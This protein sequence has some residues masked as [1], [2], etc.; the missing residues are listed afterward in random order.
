MD[1]DEAARALDLVRVKEGKAAMLAL[2][3]P[4]WGPMLERLM[5]IPNVGWITGLEIMFRLGA[6]M[7]EGDG[8][9]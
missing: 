6:R 9:S 7:R 4:A 1:F 3:P 2:L 5:E 8:L